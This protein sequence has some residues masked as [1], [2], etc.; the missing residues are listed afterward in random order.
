MVSDLRGQLP[1]RVP[2]RRRVRPLCCQP[3]APELVPQPG[4]LLVSAAG[5]WTPGV[6]AWGGG[7]HNRSRYLQGCGRGGWTGGG[8]RGGWVSCR[9]MHGGREGR[10]GAGGWV[11]PTGEMQQVAAGSARRALCTGK[12]RV[13]GN[14]PVAEQAKKHT[15][16]LST[17]AIRR[18]GPPWESPRWQPYS[19]P[20]A[21][22]PTQPMQQAHSGHPSPLSPC[23]SPTQPMQS[24]PARV[25]SP[26]T[27]HHP[28]PSPWPPPG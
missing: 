27:A 11:G 7:E 16:T 9:G 19:V 13:S 14:Q 28:E 26:L 18:Q 23:S 25:T 3:Q 10:Q 8:A 24:H 6:W 5:V 20:P 21:H 15:A 12:A 4:R 1:S 2:G 17:V 22:C